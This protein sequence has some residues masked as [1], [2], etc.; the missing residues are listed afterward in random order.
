M[1]RSSLGVVLTCEMC[2]R[3]A[4]EADTL[5]WTTSVEHGR[6]RWFCAECS[7]EHLR[8]IEGKLD[9]EFW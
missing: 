2:G 5:T 7:R 9:S 8:S 6:R 4:E 1:V 3:R